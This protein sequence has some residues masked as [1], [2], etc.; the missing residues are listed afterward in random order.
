MGLFSKKSSDTVKEAA[1]AVRKLS[2][3]DKPKEAKPATE[4]KVEAE[5]QAEVKTET[6]VEEPI[7][8]EAVKD[9]KGESPTAVASAGQNV[10]PADIQ[11][12]SLRRVRRGENSCGCTAKVDE[13]S[14]PWLLRCVSALVTKS[15][16]VPIVKLTAA[17]TALAE[18]RRSLRHWKTGRSAI[19]TRRADSQPSLPP[20]SRVSPQ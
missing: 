13:Q 20:R 5:P 17:E 12:M 19:V 2:M 10:P 14:S 6:K 18:K 15:S 8:A 11:P 3:S 4:S 7:S 1:E 9:E 16:L